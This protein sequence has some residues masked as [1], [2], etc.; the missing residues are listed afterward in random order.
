MKWNGGLPESELE[1]ML[2]VWEAGEE[3][4]TAPGI[5]ARLER[6]LT[7]SAL[8]SYLKRLEEK[9]FLSCGKE[10]KTNRY[11]ARVSRA[12]YEQQESRTVLDRLYAGSL[13]R[14]AAAPPRRREPDGRG[15]AGAGGVPPHAEAGGV[16]WSR[17][18]YGC[19]PCR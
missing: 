9:G 7:A 14:F 16:G 17:C 10:G 15:G 11:R 12:E 2:A 1:L 18:L 13:R 3:G 4:T 19:S 5:L 8:H 6:P